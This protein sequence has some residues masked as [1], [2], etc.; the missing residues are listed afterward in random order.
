[1]QRSQLRNFS[2]CCGLS[3]SC[4]SSYPTSIVNDKSRRVS[5]VFL[6]NR[7]FGLGAEASGREFHKQ[8][9]IHVLLASLFLS[10]SGHDY[11]A[12]DLFPLLRWAAEPRISRPVPPSLWLSVRVVACVPFPLPTLLERLCGRVLVSLQ[13]L[14]EQS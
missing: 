4:Q 3:R 2:R 7:L 11:L 10:P 9:S 14:A 13:D 1:M 6:G 8:F 12:G 5:I